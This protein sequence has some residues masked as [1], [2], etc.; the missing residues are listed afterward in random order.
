[1]CILVVFLPAS[2]LLWVRF[3]D[4]PPVLQCSYV[5]CKVFGLGFAVVELSTRLLRRIW[6]GLRGFKFTLRGAYGFWRREAP[7]CPK[8]ARSAAP[9]DRPVRPPERR[10]LRNNKSTDFLC[11]GRINKVD[12][13][14][15][16]GS[17]SEKNENCDTLILNDSTVIWLHLHPSGGP[18]TRK[19]LTI[20]ERKNNNAYEHTKSQKKRNQGHTKSILYRKRWK[21]GLTGSTGENPV[22]RR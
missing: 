22:T 8:T 14:S 15:P 7:P 13:N 1:M 9:S 2:T 17:E 12:G 16:Q 11:K 3:L 6:V 21:K 19:K 20:F 10:F 5:P 4:F 18:G